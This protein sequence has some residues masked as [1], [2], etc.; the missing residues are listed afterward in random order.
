VLLAASCFSGVL[1]RLG[2]RGKDGS[3]YDCITD[4]AMRDWIIPFLF[5]LTVSL[6]VNIDFRVWWVY[7]LT[8]ILMGGAFTTYW[9]WLFN[10]KDN[11]FMSGFMVGLSTIPLEAI[12]IHRYSVLIYSVLLMVIWGSI[13]KWFPKL[14]FKDIGTPREFLRYMSVI[15]TIPLL[16]I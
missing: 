4:T 11:L 2:G 8:Y 16:W 9:D 15:L 7:L 1:G 5:L 3:W 6:K 14:W 13:E 10:N 12:G